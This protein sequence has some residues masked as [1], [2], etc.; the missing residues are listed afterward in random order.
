MSKTRLLSIA[1][2]SLLLL[3]IAMVAVMVMRRGHQPGQEANAEGK[4]EPKWIVIE[5]LHLDKEQQA[6][7]QM[8]I[9]AHKT[10]HHQLN[11]AC[12]DL[13]NKLYSLLEKTPVDSLLAD[14]LI[15]QVAHKQREL[16]QLNFKHFQQVKAI[17]RPEQMNDF[18]LLA[19]DLV[20]IFAHRGPPPA[21]Q[22]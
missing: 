17:C 2:I 22:K 1:L 4:R 21:K 11:D 18:N 20:D 6:A 3:N 14:S 12:R 19:A 15:G 8:L 13:K 10:K 16:E 5:R 9:D 7:Y